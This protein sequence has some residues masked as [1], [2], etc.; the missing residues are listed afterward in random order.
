MNSLCISG[1]SLCL[2]KHPSVAYIM[3]SFVEVRNS[4]LYLYRKFVE[5]IIY[6]KKVFVSS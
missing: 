2:R 4:P 3:L 1:L 5:D 6:M